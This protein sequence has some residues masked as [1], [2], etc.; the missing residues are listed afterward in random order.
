M[1]LFS[2][3]HDLV[4]ERDVVCTLALSLRPEARRGSKYICKSTKTPSLDLQTSSYVGQWTS[5]I[6]IAVSDV[7]SL[8]YSHHLLRAYDAL[9][10]EKNC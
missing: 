7:R 6:F 5:L 8:Y 4:A 9:E 3:E 10:S 1:L 2:E